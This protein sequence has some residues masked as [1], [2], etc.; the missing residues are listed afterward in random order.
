MHR[1]ERRH[2]LR[3]ALSSCPVLGEH[4]DPVLRAWGELHVIADLRPA[5]VLAWAEANALGCDRS[6]FLRCVLALIGERE[7]LR[8]EALT[9]GHS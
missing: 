7:V 2:G 5:D 4:L 8:S 1:A 6:W 9:N 3:S